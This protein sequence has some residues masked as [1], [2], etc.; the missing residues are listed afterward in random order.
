MTVWKLL[1]TNLNLRV[2]TIWQLLKMGN[3]LV[4]FLGQEF[5]LNTENKLSMYRTF[6]IMWLRNSKRWLN[7]L[8]AWRIANIS[9]RN[10]LYL[11][12]LIVGL[13]SGLSALVLKNLIH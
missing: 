6:K 4:L 12:S 5:L 7:K 10:F 9:E 3:T 13:L 8:V 2:D 11:L 1:P